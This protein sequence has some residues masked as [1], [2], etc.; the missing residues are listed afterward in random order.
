MLYPPNDIEGVKYLSIKKLK[1]LLNR[2]EI[3]DEDLIF[4]NSV[5]NLAILDREFNFKGYI[6]FL[7]EGE[8]EIYPEGLAQ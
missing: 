1:E 5:G 4:P 7:L 2:K 3:A 8:I 6:D